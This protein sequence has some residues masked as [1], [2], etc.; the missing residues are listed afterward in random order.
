MMKTK[1]IRAKPTKEE[2]RNRS[3]EDESG[4]W[5]WQGHVG[6]N[7]YGERGSGGRRFYVHRLSYELFKGEIPAGMLVHHLCEVRRCV[8]PDHLELRTITDHG[9]EHGASRLQKMT[10]V[11]GHPKKWYGRAWVCPTCAVRFSREKRR[12][13]GGR[14][15]MGRVG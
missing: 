1:R 10:C 5:L 8:N 6:V 3:E 7:G 13:R 9:G 2:M 11:Y 14:K 4:C 15:G 12:R